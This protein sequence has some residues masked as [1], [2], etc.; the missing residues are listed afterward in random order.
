[1]EKKESKDTHKS[2]SNEVKFKGKTMFHF[3]IFQQLCP[4]ELLAIEG[5]RKKSKSSFYNISFDG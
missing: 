1:M 2:L 4:D 5:F 3:H